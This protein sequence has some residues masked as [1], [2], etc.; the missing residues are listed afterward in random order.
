MR[1]NDEDVALW[2]VGRR[3]SDAGREAGRK[4]S[5]PATLR[6]TPAFTTNDGSVAR[7]WAEEGLGL[8]LRS[9]WDVADAVAAGEVV[10][11]SGGVGFFSA[12][13]D[14]RR[15]IRHTGCLRVH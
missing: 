8:V 3:R 4:S 2:R 6:V 7:R 13:R 9:Q 10:G 12:A 5:V 14:P 15:G 1:E 11:G